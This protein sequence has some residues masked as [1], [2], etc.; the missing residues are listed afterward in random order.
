MVRIA[1]ACALCHRGRVAHMADSLSMIRNNCK[2]AYKCNSPQPVPHSFFLT[3]H[4]GQ[5]KR[6]VPQSKQQKS[7]WPPSM[8]LRRAQVKSGAVCSGSMNMNLFDLSLACV[9]SRGP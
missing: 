4:T 3:M 6:L 1:K 9:A 8:R 2:E 5:T 7:Q